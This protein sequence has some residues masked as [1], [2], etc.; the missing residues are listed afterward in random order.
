MEKVKKNNSEIRQNPLESTPYEF[1]S[2]PH[3]V[4][5]VFSKILLCMLLLGISVLGSVF[6]VE[7]QS[8]FWS[9]SFYPRNICLLRNPYCRYIN[10]VSTYTVEW[11]LTSTYMQTALNYQFI[12]LR[13]IC[14]YNKL[15]ILIV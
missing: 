3:S 2:V 13:S 4:R 6:A 9:H 1:S 10:A 12:K 14:T 11:F 5:S 15:R 7:M 8:L